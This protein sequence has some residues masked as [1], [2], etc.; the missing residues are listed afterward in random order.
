[1][2]ESILWQIHL[3]AGDQKKSIGATWSGHGKRG[4]CRT[5]YD[6]LTR[7]TLKSEGSSEAMNVFMR[8]SLNAGWRIKYRGNQFEEQCNHYSDFA[9]VLS[10]RIHNGQPIL[11]Y[12]G[13]VPAVLE[14]ERYPSPLVTTP[15]LDFNNDTHQ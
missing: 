8:S 11:K 4:D 6:Q 7:S 13:G 15:T 1:M 3:K 10:N 12:K 9:I 2:S 14:L 5:P